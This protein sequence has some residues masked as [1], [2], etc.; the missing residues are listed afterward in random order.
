VVQAAAAEVVPAAEVV[1]PGAERD[2]AF[3]VAFPTLAAAS[4]PGRPT[5][6]PALVLG[7]LRSPQTAAAAFVLRE[8]LDRPLCKRR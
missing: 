5:P 2:A 3:E 1:K 6:V 4:R 8:I 7:L